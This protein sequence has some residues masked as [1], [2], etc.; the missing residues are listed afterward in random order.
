[1]INKFLTD[2]VALN[3]T[4]LTNIKAQS[5]D[6]SMP[7][8]K[9]SYQILRLDEVP[10]EPLE[11]AVNEE[12]VS[13]VLRY[14]ILTS[15]VGLAWKM[16]VIFN[17]SQ[18]L[19]TLPYVS[20]EFNPNYGLG[21]FV[22]QQVN[23]GALSNQQYKAVLEI[24]KLEQ[25]DALLYAL[26]DSNSGTTFVITLKSPSGIKNVITSPKKFFFPREIY[27][28]IYKGILPPP[29]RQEYVLH[30][31]L[32]GGVTYPYF[33][34][35][36]RRR[37]LFHLPDR[38]VLGKDVSSQ[39]P[40]LS[41]WFSEEE[42]HIHV[43]FDVCL[44]TEVNLTRIAEALREFQKEQPDGVLYPLNT[45]THTSVTLQLPGG[46]VEPD[47]VRIDL[48][49]CILMSF[50]VP[51]EDLPVV[52]DAL[53]DNSP[54]NLLLKGDLKVEIEGFDP[55]Y[56]PIKISMPAEYENEPSKFIDARDK[57]TTTRT[58]TFISAS[59]AFTNP[60]AQITSMLI[61]IGGQT[62]ELT[63]DNPQQQVQVQVPI[64]DII[65]GNPDEVTYNY[66]LMVRYT[67]RPEW[68]TQR[69][70]NFSI[71]YVP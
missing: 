63:K 45:A 4:I 47:R 40:M 8:K 9:R 49:S 2:L 32:F 11:A 21:E 38:Y 10:P 66:T 48:Q 31:Y 22:F 51:Q 46:V 71:I 39:L 6:P 54:M 57:A 68:V 52:W 17:V 44:L 25:R 33:Q 36:V 7:Q 3:Q 58:V 20:M 43:H 34:D 1:M 28:Y 19:S 53:F 70:S 69:Q 61:L 62:I 41:L 37:E 24:D 27:D 29:P 14:S 67:D 50:E 64:L 59:G 16:E 65:L 12:D 13:G 23:Q 35:N 26:S 5:T 42:G 55:N 56:V 30:R 15:D 18:P 60:V